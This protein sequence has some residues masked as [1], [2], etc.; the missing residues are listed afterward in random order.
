MTGTNLF[1]REEVY[2]TAELSKKLGLGVSVSFL[3]EC[4]ISP[5]CRTS[6]GTFWRKSDF[7]IICHAISKAILRLSDI[8]F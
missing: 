8:P 7:P 6:T 2:S 3:Q 1:N 5:L 4:G